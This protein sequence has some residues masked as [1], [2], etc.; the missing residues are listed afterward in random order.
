MHSVHSG[1]FY[2]LHVDDA[3]LRWH[4]LKLTRTP[5]L[6]VGASHW[7]WRPYRV[8]FEFA[9]ALDPFGLS[10]DDAFRI[11]VGKRL[12]PVP[13]AIGF[14]SQTPGPLPD[15]MSTG[16]F[17]LLVVEG[18]AD[19]IRRHT[20]PDEVQFIPAKLSSDPNRPRHLLNALKK[21]RC[22]DLHQSRVGFFPD[23]PSAVDGI[24]RL[25]P[26]NLVGAPALF[27]FAECIT[28]LILNQSLAADLQNAS[29]SCGRFFPL[30]DHRRPPSHCSTQSR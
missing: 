24:E 14:H 6:V 5:P 13:T 3:D 7:V 10:I 2:P 21:R 12:D 16:G 23:C 18:M 22:I 28:E 15:V 25:V 11:S 29:S 4:P 20:E 27:H 8:G 1:D 26:R 19:I 17:G 30:A 9:S